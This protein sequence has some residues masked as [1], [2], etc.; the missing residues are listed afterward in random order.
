MPRGAR[1]SPRRKQLPVRMETGQLGINLI[2]RVVLEMKC[3]W[4]PTVAIDTGIDGTIEL[5]DQEDPPHPLGLIL[6][7]QSRATERGTWPNETL[8]SFTF[9]P[10]AVDLE[11]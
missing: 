7:M 1:R 2:E 6:H 11:Y 5:T 8:T 4:H 10:P 9:A 3:R